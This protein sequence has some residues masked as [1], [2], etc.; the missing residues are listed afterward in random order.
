[1]CQFYTH[2]KLI[3]LQGYILQH[4]LWKEWEKPKYPPIWGTLEKLLKIHK[5]EYCIAVKNK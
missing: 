1:M 3:Y 2:A 5:A 4:S